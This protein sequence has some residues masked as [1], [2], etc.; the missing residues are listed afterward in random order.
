MAELNIA[1]GGIDVGKS[2][3]DVALC[4]SG[5]RLHTTNDEAGHAAVAAF[6]QR[7]GVS[8]AG[9]EASGGYERPLA[10]HLRGAGFAV[11]VFKPI[12]VRALAVFR[13]QRAKNDPIDARLIALAA[14]AAEDAV[15]KP[16][17]RLEDLAQDLT[18]VEQIEEDIVRAKT[19]REAAAGH[20]R[21]HWQSEI[22]RL[23]ALR[24]SELDRI[25]AALLAHGDLARRLELVLSVPGIGPRTAI[26]LIIRMPELGRL[27]RE[28]IASLAGLAPFD[29][30]SA[31]RS[32]QRHIK[33]GRGRLLQPLRCCPPRRLPLEQRP[34]HLLQ[35]TQSQGKTPQTRPRRLRQKTPHLR[36]HRPR[37]R[38]TMDPTNRP[39]LMVAHHGKERDFQPLLPS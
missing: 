14:A 13:Q 39:I 23:L 1:A 26:A 19:R 10:R 4:G 22:R 38:N 7:H 32:G 24:K 8:R 25:R 20:A 31:T 34:H 5:E 6:L 33:D 17:T 9:M 30:D 35:T 27:S 21:D 18:L 16:D 29:D 3:L 11:I 12:R 37:K 28:R 2:V 15:I 36:K